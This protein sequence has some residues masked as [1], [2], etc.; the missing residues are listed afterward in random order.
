M[1]RNADEHIRMHMK[2]QDLSKRREMQG[3]TWM[4]MN[5]QRCI[6]M[7]ELHMAAYNFLLNPYRNAILLDLNLHH[8]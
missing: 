7:L 3:S 8:I 2:A 5:A 1:H 4:L 6:E